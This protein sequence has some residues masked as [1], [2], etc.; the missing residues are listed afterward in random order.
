MITRIVRHADEL[1]HQVDVVDGARHQIAG[2]V[3]REEAGTLMLQVGINPLTQIVCDGNA[4]APDH[5]AADDDAG[6]LT[7]HAQHDRK[8]GPHERGPRGGHVD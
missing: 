2:G 5:A 1:P 8:C 4:D 7:E 3:P 6:E